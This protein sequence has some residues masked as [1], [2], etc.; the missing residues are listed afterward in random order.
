MFSDIDDFLID[1]C[2]QPVCDAIRRTTG[3]SKGVPTA[4]GLLITAIGLVPLMIATFFFGVHFF[5][6]FFVLAG[7][8]LRLII[9]YTLHAYSLLYNDSR[10]HRRTDALDLAR[11][12]GERDRKQSLILSIMLLPV[13]LATCTYPAPGAQI[14][15]FF[16]L[17]GMIAN[18]CAAYFKAC[19]DLPPPR[20]QTLTER[21]RESLPYRPHPQP[22]E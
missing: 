22:S 15:A 16:L 2:F 9:I 10:R 11:L 13:L 3:C 4:I 7:I 12:A 17:V 19:T 18:I 21:L 1:R 5:W 6:T 8:L 14:V 20:R